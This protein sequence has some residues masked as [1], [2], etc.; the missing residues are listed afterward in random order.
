MGWLGRL[1]G[2]QKAIDSLVDKDNG[3]LSQVGNWVGGMHYS[4]E[5]KA[6][7]DAITRQWGLSQLD[8]L[9]PFKITQRVMAFAATFIWVT[10]ALALLLMT[11]N[12]H[13]QLDQLK[14]LAMS[15]YIWLPVSL[16][17]TLYFGGGAIESFKR[18]KSK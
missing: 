11:A 7:A 10:Y 13:P 9:Q 5:E 4:E 15:N 14:E 2:T 8:S 17:Y 1:F 12:D 18:S 6:E 3:L 16:V